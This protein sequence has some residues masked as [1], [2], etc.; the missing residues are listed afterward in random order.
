[1]NKSIEILSRNQSSKYL[2]SKTPKSNQPNHNFSHCNDGSQSLEATGSF[3][4]P[5]IN[6]KSRQIDR[7]TSRSP[8]GRQVDR[9]ERLYKNKDQQN[10]KLEALRQLY[11]REESPPEEKQK[12][13]SR[14]P[15]NINSVI[16]R[17]TQWQIK[18]DLKINNL[19]IQ[20]ENEE[21]EK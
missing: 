1:M 13:R 6:E 21:A 3:F 19:R 11:K 8:Y 17:N 2:Y 16:D 14:T 4:N 15:I 10:A 7:K 18:K 5:T 20:K 9:F 12:F